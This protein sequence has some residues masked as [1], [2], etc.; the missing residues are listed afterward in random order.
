MAD[1][2]AA[3]ARRALALVASRRGDAWAEMTASLAGLTLSFEG[4]GTLTLRG[5]GVTLAETNDVGR[6]SIRLRVDR[7]TARDLI[8][9]R[10]TLTGAIRSGRLDLAGEVAA[11]ERAVRAFE[12]FVGAL[13]RID[14]SEALRLALQEGDGP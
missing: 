1:S 3:L 9:G 11:L 2:L 6:A 14:E 5:D 7:S 13:L 8:D 12:A 4:D 10:V